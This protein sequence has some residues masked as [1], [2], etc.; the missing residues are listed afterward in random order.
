[1]KC[2]SAGGRL[3]RL[4]ASLHQPTRASTACRP[5]QGQAAPPHNP[6]ATT[7]GRLSRGAAN[8]LPLLSRPGGGWPRTHVGKLDMAIVASLSEGLP[9]RNSTIRHQFC[10]WGARSRHGDVDPVGGGGSAG[11]SGAPTNLRGR[12]AHLLHRPSTLPLPTHW[13]TRHTAS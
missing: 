11:A 13:R 5:Q 10:P 3:R 2:S 6:R 9:L 7:G 1:M 4:L 12:G 8:P